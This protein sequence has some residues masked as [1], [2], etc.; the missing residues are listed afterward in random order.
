MLTEDIKKQIVYKKFPAKIEGW[1]DVSAYVEEELKKHNIDK[2]HIMELL[3]TFEELFVNISLYAYKDTPKGEGDMTLGL[4]YVDGSI[5]MQFIDEGVE[6]D[7]TAKKDPDLTLSAEDRN[8]GGLGIYM[9]KTWADEFSYVRENN[10]NVL[11]FIK[12]I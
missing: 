8:I 4:G 11:T 12:K 3:I 6:F 9:A 10:K 2:K 7:P 1:E 5:Y